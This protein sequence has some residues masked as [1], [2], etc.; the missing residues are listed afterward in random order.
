MKESTA[1]PYN[2]SDSMPINMQLWNWKQARL[3]YWNNTC[4]N[5]CAHRRSFWGDLGGLSPPKLCV[6]EVI[7]IAKR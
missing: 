1:A 2:G 5:K 7:K 4:I 6:T 3:P